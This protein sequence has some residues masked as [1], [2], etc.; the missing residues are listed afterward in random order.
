MKTLLYN[1]RTKALLSLF[2]IFIIT[3]IVSI[4]FYPS[5]GVGA[6]SGHGYAENKITWGI[7][8]VVFMGVYKNCWDENCTY[9]LGYTVKELIAGG[10]TTGSFTIPAG[11]SSYVHGVE[12]P[13]EVEF[14][15]DVVINFFLSY[16]FISLLFL[17]HIHFKNIKLKSKPEHV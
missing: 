8:P 11:S 9:G 10:M 14:V 2:F 4:F 3:P 12:V 13:L 17:L 1:F 15:L 16:L 6:A 7:Y 5:Y